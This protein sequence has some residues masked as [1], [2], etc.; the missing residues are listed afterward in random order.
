MSLPQLPH[1]ASETG[2]DKISWPNLIGKH[3]QVLQQNH[4]DSCRA[5]E[6]AWRLGWAKSSLEQTQQTVRLFD[7]LVG[8]R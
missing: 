3:I 8:E 7:H 6:W 4:P 1:R 5:D 2:H